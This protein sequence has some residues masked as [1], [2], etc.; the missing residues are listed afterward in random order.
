VDNAASSSPMAW[1]AT[2]TDPWLELDAG[3]NTTPGEFLVS[4]YG[5]EAEVPG[6][7]QTV[8]TVTSP[9]DPDDREQVAV[10]VRAVDKVYRVW[11]P[12]IDN[13]HSAP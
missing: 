5:F 3:Q 6:T 13:G 7:Q 9:Q 12:L 2:S 4:A 10:T 11:L 1:S 8:I